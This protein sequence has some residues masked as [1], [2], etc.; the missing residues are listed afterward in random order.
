M[1]DKTPFTYS[2]GQGSIPRVAVKWKP[3]GHRIR[4]RPGMT[5]RRTF[6]TEA[7]SIDHSWGTLRTLAQDCVRLRDFVA[8]LIMT[9]RA[10]YLID[11]LI[12]MTGTER[13]AC[14][15]LLQLNN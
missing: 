13:I 1:Y 6:E 2:K 11:F 4:G 5:W 10:V 7:T 15:V 9:I 12:V 8:A 14:D 3:E